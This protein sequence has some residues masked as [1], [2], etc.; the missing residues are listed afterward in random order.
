MVGLVN[1]SSTL[2]RPE[3]MEYFLVAYAKVNIDKDEGIVLQ[4]IYFGGL[5]ST[6]SEAETLARE[7]V[8]TIRGGTIF[9]RIMKIEE[10]H[11]LIDTLYDAADKFEI[12]TKGME[13]TNA[14]IRRGRK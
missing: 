13:E 2:R 5:S 8:N 1:L 11:R 14:I 4:G 3:T 10:P 7:C 12:V 9:P 6:Y